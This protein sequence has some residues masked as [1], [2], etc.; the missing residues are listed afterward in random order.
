MNKHC[1]IVI[2]LIVALCGG[3]NSHDVDS[4]SETEQGLKDYFE[5][6]RNCRLIW[7]NLFAEWE[8]ENGGNF[9]SI[10]K[11]RQS[12]QNDKVTLLSKL[13]RENWKHQGSLNQSE[14]RQ[15][16]GYWPVSDDAYRKATS[17]LFLVGSS[18]LPSDCILLNWLE[19]SVPAMFNG[20]IKGVVE[21]GRDDLESP[22][23]KKW[24]I[25]W[26]FVNVR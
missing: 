26:L 22:H 1:F 8:G 25:Y 5:S 6:S 14:L 4:L 12:I 3:C 18:E 24:V 21:L 20:S 19:P 11:V 9:N 16:I 23:D 15:N 7:S 17:L 2:G 13:V 10:E